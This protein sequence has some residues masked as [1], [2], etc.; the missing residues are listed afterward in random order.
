VAFSGNGQF[1]ASGSRDGAV[2]LWATNPR[3]RSEE[4]AGVRLPLGLSADGQRLFALTRDNQV[5]LVNV[6][7]G[8]VERHISLHV[9]YTN[10]A[11]KPRVQIASNPAV[12]ASLNTVAAVLPDGWL[13]IWHVDTGHDEILAN[14]DQVNARLAL[15]P[16]GRTL[17]SGGPDL[18]WW[19]LWRNTRT[20]TS[21]VGV[22]PIFSGDGRKLIAIGP[23][24]I[25]EVWD[26][27]S[28]QMRNQFKAGTRINFA[29]DDCP[30]AVSP[31]GS[32]LAIAGSN[33]IIEVWSTQSA[34]LMG[35]FIGHK[36]AIASIAF[37][38]DVKTL[39]SASDD[40]TLKFWNLG[41]QQELLTIRR[42]GGAFRGL[43][44]AAD[45]HS[46]VAG[47]SL[48]VPGGGVRVFRAALYADI[49]ASENR[50]P[51]R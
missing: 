31:D 6:T 39:V 45:G 49:D 28:R 42:F 25:V 24:G 22:L 17:V 13:K 35:S 34:Q 4:L 41:T 11:G 10:E 7:N 33:D 21:S 50:R 23:E 32:R 12:S 43:A 2:K 9:A 47:T 15:S 27:A 8:S 44:F 1:I 36:Q 51:A 38:P 14:P 3:P 19:D 26:S 48:I 46:L 18:C 40:G 20:P 16:D 29:L 37:C 5:A 30:V